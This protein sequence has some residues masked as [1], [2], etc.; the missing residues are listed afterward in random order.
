MYLLR[1]TSTGEPIGV[2]EVHLKSASS[3]WTGASFEVELRDVDLR[4]LALMANIPLVALSLEFEPH[5]V[6][7]I[8]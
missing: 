4:V 1:L 5:L 2:Q 6:R 7:G 8:D 3:K